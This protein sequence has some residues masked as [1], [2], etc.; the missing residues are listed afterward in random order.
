M[1]HNYCSDILS[2][3]REELAG[4]MHNYIHNRARI[5]KKNASLVLQ[6]L[7]NDVVLSVARSRTILKG[8]KEKATWETFMAGYVAYHYMS[9]QYRLAELLA[10]RA[11]P[12]C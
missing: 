7:V 1:A 2:F 4:E 8:E 9:P 5:I 10:P 3:Y 6:E 11:K 12:T